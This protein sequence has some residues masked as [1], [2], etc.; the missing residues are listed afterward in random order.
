MPF[1]GMAIKP[2]DSVNAQTA[3]V[4]AKNLRKK[5]A[6]N[7]FLRAFFLVYTL[8]CAPFIVISVGLMRSDPPNA[9]RKKFLQVEKRFVFVHCGKVDDVKQIGKMF[10]GSI[11]DVM[12]AILCG[13]LRK[14]QIHTDGEKSAKDMTLIIPISTRDP[15]EKGV[16]LDN[17]VGG[18]KARE[19]SRKN[20]ILTASLSNKQTLPSRMLHTGLNSIS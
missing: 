17:Q 18:A 10:R 11:N 1:A 7:I 19:A 16:I 9:F 15:K 3:A 4:G 14:Y 20:F 12:V 5:Q 8:L 2:T 13:T 6:P